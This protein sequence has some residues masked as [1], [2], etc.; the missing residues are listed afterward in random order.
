[1]SVIVPIYN[2]DKYL[3]RCLDSLVANNS[4]NVEFI[5]VD[6][7]SSDKSA[8]ICDEY[9]NKHANFKVIHKKNGGL[10]SARKAGFQQAVGKYIWFIDG[11]DFIESDSISKIVDKM[12]ADNSQLAYI[13]YNIYSASQQYPQSFPYEQDTISKSEIQNLY[14]KPLF[15]HLPE[16]KPNINA[17]LWQR[18]M[19]R[20]L[21][22]EECFIHENKYF[23]EDAIFDLMYIKNVTTISLIN[24]HIYNYVYNSTSLSNKIRENAWQMR[25]NLFQFFIQYCS[26]NKISAENRLL[27]AQ[28]AGLLYSIQNYSRT[29]Y[30]TFKHYYS[31]IC[32][33]SAFKRITSIK[34]LSPIL[35]QQMNNYRLVHLIC[36]YLTPRYIYKFY[37]WRQSR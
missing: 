33:D 30:S 23:A 22:T 10:S 18:I 5:L 35:K 25:K 7:G 29:D 36:K 15:G 2:I 13:G 17:F 9:V 14:I 16:I 34:L 12:E 6:D 24:C 26:D 4:E 28:L 37:H 1:M 27:S 31:Q 32:N 3:R 19:I 20:N 21:I 11:D 8:E